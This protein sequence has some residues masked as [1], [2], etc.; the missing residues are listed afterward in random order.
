MN[1]CCGWCLKVLD[2]E[3]PRPKKVFCSVGCRDANT[4]FEEMFSDEEI[5][6]KAHYWELTHPPEEGGT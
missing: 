3:I 4:I 2:T 1:R 6:R 5:N